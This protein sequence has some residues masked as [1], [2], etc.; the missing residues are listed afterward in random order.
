MKR[1]HFKISVVAAALLATM[2]AHA[3]VT[4]E[5]VAQLGK[6]L[7]PVGADPNGNK[8]GTIPKWGGAT[9]KP[10]GNWTYGKNRIEY[11]KHKDEK[12]LFV[13]DASNVDKYKDK[14]TPGQV[15]MITSLKG[16]EMRVY[17][18]HRDCS[19]PDF[20]L[21]NTA[22]GAIKSKIAANGWSLEEASLP[23]V[24]FPIPK[25]GIEAVW[26]YL[27]RYQ[28]VGIWWPDAYTTVSPKPGSTAGIVTRWDQMSYYPWGRKGTQ[29]PSQVHGI[30]QGFYYGFT[31][32]VALA[33]QKLIQTY[34]FDKDVESF[35]YFTGQRRVR[36]LPSYAYDTPL[37][38]FENQY[39]NDSLFMYYGNPDRFD[40]KVVGKKEIY[41]PYSAFESVNLKHRAQGMGPYIDNEVRRYELHRVWVIE[42]DLKAGARHSTPKKV[43]YLDEDTWLAAAA[44]E[45]DTKGTLWRHKEAGIM[46]AWEIGSCENATLVFFHD[47]S[48]GRYVTDSNVLGG[49]KDTKFLSDEKEDPRFSM[50]FYTPENLRSISE[51]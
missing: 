25:S 7:T 42:G 29:S 30:Q 2:A 15:G 33:G 28:G 43:L 44:E 4:A 11:W 34:F 18:T 45:Y 24:P 12:P 41:I 16:Y 40:W 3:G 51:R 26:N 39:P 22:K 23:G 20:V 32:P 50:N 21:D 38:G 8:D 46:P 10:V 14:L 19:Y 17:P 37:I 48:N 6:T 47:F 5:E 35:Y 36:R 13:I 31:E 27:M 1:I 9:D 49:G